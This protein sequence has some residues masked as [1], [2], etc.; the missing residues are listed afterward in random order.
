MEERRQTHFKIIRLQMI[1]FRFGLLFLAILFLSQCAK[2]TAS[3]CNLTTNLCS[4]DRT[5]LT[6]N[7]DCRDYESMSTTTA[8][9]KCS[10][11]GG[12]FKTTALCTSSS[13]VGTCKFTSGTEITYQRYYQANYSTAASAAVVCAY[14]KANCFILSGNALCDGVWTND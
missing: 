10:K 12:T 6:E 8:S 14:Y 5:A 13:R 7:P 11:D 3:D 9:S 2:P 4:C 1:H